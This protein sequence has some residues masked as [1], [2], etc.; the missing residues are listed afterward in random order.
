MNRLSLILKCLA[1]S[2]LALAV[3]HASA[4][5]VVYIGFDANDQAANGTIPVGSAFSTVRTV[6]E[7]TLNI[8][9]TG[10]ETFGANASAAALSLPVLGGAA[11]ITQTNLFVPSTDPFDPPGT[12]V[13][14]GLRG[15]VRNTPSGGRFNTTRD[16]L[17]NQTA[18]AFWET[19]GIFTLNLTN[20]FQAFG[21]DATDFGDFGSVLTMSLFNG[22]QQGAVLSYQRPAGINPP[23]GSVLFYGFSSETEF[24][25]IVFSITQQTPSNI[26]RY[27]VVGF[28]QFTVGR[29]LSAPP[30]GNVPEPGSLALVGLALAGLGLSRRT[31]KVA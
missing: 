25:R 5:P 27:D 2:G 20:N 22:T 31:K 26:G 1:S 4:A 12:M 30:S 24:N 29:L 6:F 7:S 17:G 9:S 3:S 21:F 23:S 8:A 16:G 10:R 18:G 15:Q 11:T 13:D 28:D 19:D 14:V